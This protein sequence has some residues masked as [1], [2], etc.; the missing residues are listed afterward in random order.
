MSLWVVEIVETPL[1]RLRDGDETALASEQKSA[2]QLMT[3][4]RIDVRRRESQ[5]LDVPHSSCRPRMDVGKH[6]VLF[7]AHPDLTKL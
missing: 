7:V 5:L 1:D 3:L 6:Q 4:V 2:R